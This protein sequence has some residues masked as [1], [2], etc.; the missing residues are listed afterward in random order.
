MN[1][2]IDSRGGN[3]GRFHWVNTDSRRTCSSWVFW[4]DWWWDRAGER[5]LST[6]AFWE[7]DCDKSST[8]AEQ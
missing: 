6:P 3:I 1:W 2:L 5:T 7:G 8:S 4:G